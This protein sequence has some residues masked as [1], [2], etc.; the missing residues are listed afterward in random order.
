M[1]VSPG[2]NDAFVAFQLAGPI[3]RL[4]KYGYT[5]S[6]VEKDNPNIAPYC[7]CKQYVGMPVAFMGASYKETKVVSH[8]T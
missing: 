2:L 6:C 3:K 5:A 7:F 1:K 8:S 4:N